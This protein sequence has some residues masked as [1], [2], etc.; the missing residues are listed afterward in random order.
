MPRRKQTV[1]LAYGSNL[2]LPQMAYRCPTA[3]ILGAAELHGY[4]L[5]FRGGDGHAVA[6]V[7]PGDGSVPALL[8]KL[9]P[10]DEAA[11][12]RYEGWPRL[13]RKETVEVE[14][15]GKP[16]TAMVYIMNGGYDLGS[17]FA[18]YLD[19][20]RDGYHS[21]GFDEAVLDLAVARSVPEHAREYG[22]EYAPPDCP[23]Q[24]MDW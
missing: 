21:A 3:E 19:T 16:V 1:Y 20:I 13:Y 6:T 14:A 23:Q 15:G 7:E 5:K 18:G 12:D 10:Q 24:E 4:D 22:L 2:N 17:P 9:R 11:L 8:W